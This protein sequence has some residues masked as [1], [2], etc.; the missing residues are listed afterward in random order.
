MYWYLYFCSCLAYSWHTC[1]RLEHKLDNEQACKCIGG[2]TIKVHFFDEQSLKRV[3]SELCFYV[4]N[5]A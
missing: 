1:T 5:R 2:P 3:Q 4:E